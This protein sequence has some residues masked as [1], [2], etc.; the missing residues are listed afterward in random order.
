MK[1]GREGNGKR[2]AASRKAELI[3][4]WAVGELLGMAS[5]DS[6]C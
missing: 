2:R 1:E 5:G 3:R 4:D 6:R